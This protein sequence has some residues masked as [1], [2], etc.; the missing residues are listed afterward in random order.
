MASLIEKITKLFKFIF[1]GLYQMH[2]INFL[3]SYMSK[4]Q[5]F[6][7]AKLLYNSLCLSVR[8]GTHIQNQILR[9]FYIKNMSKH[10]QYVFQCRCHIIFIILAA[11]IVWL[12]GDLPMRNVQLIHSWLW[13]VR[14]AL[15]K[16][17]WMKFSL[18]WRLQMIWH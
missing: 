9:T 1:G 11:I 2:L 17:I 5:A 7:G 18:V 12:W 4:C 13:V 10:S 6:L 8:T 14:I 16:K 3:S 15:F